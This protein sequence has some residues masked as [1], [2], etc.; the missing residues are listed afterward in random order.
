MKYFPFRKNKNFFKSPNI[1][2]STLKVLSI[3]TLFVMNIS[4][5]ARTLQGN[6]WLQQ[7][8]ISPDGQ[9]IA[10][11][12]QGRI[13]IVSVKG[14]SAIPLTTNSAYH[15][16]PVWSHD[17]K[18]IAFAS[19]RNG[20][21]D[22]YIMGANG[23]NLRRLTYH[24][25]QDEPYEFS[26][27]DKNVIFGTIRHD[28]YNSVR[29]PL[30]RGLPVESNFAK[31]YAV[32]VNGGFNFLLN[33]A[34]MEH[35]HF[36]IAGER[37]IYQDNKGS[38][39]SYYRKHQVSST[40]RDIWCYDRKKDTYRQLTAFNGEDRE[41]LW[42][43]NEDFYYLSETSGS[44]NLYRS[45]LSDTAK[46]VQLTFFKEYPVR[47]LSRSKAGLFALSYNGDIYTYNEKSAPRKVK[48]KIPDGAG[49]DSKQVKIDR[50]D[51]VS[52]SVDGKQLAFAARGDI[53]VVSSDGKQIRQI[54][55]T[56]YVERTPSFSA[57]GKNIIYAVENGG[58]WDIAM[59]TIKTKL[60][61]S[62]PDQA[63]TTKLILQSAEDEFQPL[64]SP[65]GKK[66]AYVQNRDIIKIYDL[67][68][69]TDVEVLKAGNNFS[70]KDGDQDF[71]WCADSRHLMG[72]SK[73]G[74]IG[75]ERE[76]LLLSPGKHPVNISE[77]GFDDMTP[78]SSINGNTIYWLSNRGGL[79]NFTRSETQYSLYRK[80]L[81]LDDSAQAITS[82][83][84]LIY[85]ESDKSEQINTP[86]KDIKDFIVPAG[87]S[88]LFYL[89]DSGSG[90]DLYKLNLHTNQ[91]SIFSKLS[92]DDPKLSLNG[93]G[94]AI[95][96]T[97]QG[98]ATVIDLQTGSNTKVAIDKMVT[99]DIRAE[100][101]AA[102]DHAYQRVRKRFFSPELNGANF[103]KYY[104]NYKRFIPA[105][106]MTLLF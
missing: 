46:S 23:K 91:I 13:Y 20:N 36:D 45:S 38:I 1:L 100:R 28:E 104:L 80:E 82:K 27:D 77:N 15:S 41:P 31:L 48:I 18:K 5:Y 12:C 26:S 19:D 35:A 74:S 69:H 52:L 81:K 89:A 90:F 87:D 47:S 56:P 51:D 43:N 55:N 93:N 99:K 4:A 83:R 70:S 92:A 105:I 57:D 39:D 64:F 14:G 66:I 54:T 61:F 53:F 62:S 3:L 17:S 40:T 49:I 34:G 103:Q 88:T 24:S 33:S 65:D 10:F 63:I 95:V 21:N 67:E 16:S 11:A 78:R 84:S 7:P 98:Q 32:S 85:L 22:I 44:F 2:F 8:A 9:N 37:I 59:A 30:E 71:V 86:S 25:A 94:S 68:K 42:G 97:D 50:M 79:M 29:F 60:G 96:V 76:I 6:E 106:I 72:T 75:H 73:H 101:I 58:S 102:F